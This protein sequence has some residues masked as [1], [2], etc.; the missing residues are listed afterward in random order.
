MASPGGGR[1]C[2]VTQKVLLCP[3]SETEGTTSSVL[4]N[5]ASFLYE[6][7]SC[8]TA[9]A[10]LTR[11]QAWIKRMCDYT[12]LFSL[13]LILIPKEWLYPPNQEMVKDGLVS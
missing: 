3:L 11:P 8:F 9:Q 10:A 12:Q 1:V 2:T 4:Q 5:A 6:L 13:V 7:W